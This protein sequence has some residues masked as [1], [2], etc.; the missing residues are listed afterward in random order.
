MNQKSFLGSIVYITYLT[1]PSILEF[2]QDIVAMGVA[3]KP[4][5]MHILSQSAL[6]TAKQAITRITSS[7]SFMLS[8]GA[9][10]SHARKTISEPKISLSEIIWQDARQAYIKFLVVPIF[11]ISPI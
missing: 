9:I 1:K 10:S 7:Q 2:R 8:R 4:I 6:C 3:H 5:W 11:A